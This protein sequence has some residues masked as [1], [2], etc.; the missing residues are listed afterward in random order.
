MFEINLKEIPDFLAYL[1]DRKRLEMIISL[2]ILFVLPTLPYVYISIKML[3]RPFN[4]QIG[5]FGDGSMI[6]LCI[7]IVC[8]YFGRTHDFKNDGEKNKHKLFNLAAVV[9]Y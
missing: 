6:S 4:D 3:A 2:T 5:Y 9:I 8:T 1:W 7:G